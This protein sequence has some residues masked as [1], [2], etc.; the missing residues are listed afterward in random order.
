MHRV[1]GSPATPTDEVLALYHEAVS[2]ELRGIGKMA[3]E[4]ALVGADCCDTC[5]ADD[6]RTF[7][8]AAELRTPRLPHEGCPK[9]LCYCRWDL[10]IRDR[11][12]VER[13]LRRTVRPPKAKRPTA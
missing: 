3:K 4:A 7:K 6:G 5:R 12:M 9:G 2:T 8:I 1:A 10:T 13:Y 11:S